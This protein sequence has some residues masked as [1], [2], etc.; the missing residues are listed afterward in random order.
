MDADQFLDTVRQSSIY[1]DQLVHVRKLA[2]RPARYSD[3]RH[4]PSGLLG[5]TIRS[6]GIDRLYTHQAEA[7]DAVAAGRH[8]VLV[9]STASGKTLSY[10]LPVL[11]SLFADR[12]ARAIYLFP[13]KALAQDQRGKLDAFGLMPAIR[14]ATYDGDTP[15]SERPPIRRSA[16]IILT[17][18]DML[19]VGILPN[20]EQWAHFF[21]GLKFV[22]IDEIH[23]YRGV[24]G[25]H[26][27]NIMRRLRRIAAY[28]GA[29]PQ[30]ICC[31]AT[32]HNPKELAETLTGLPFAQI[33]NDG[34][35][36]G[37]RTVALWNPPETADG[38][39]RP[40]NTEAT[41][42]FLALVAS[43]IRSI[44][45]ARARVTVELMLQYARKTLNVLDD[46]SVPLVEAYRGGYTPEERRDIEKRL[47]NGSL[48]GVATTNALEL[49]VD[50]GGLDAA[51][52][53]GYPGSI[54]SFWQQIGRVGRACEPS[55]SV[56]IA[57]ND[58]LEQY[59]VRRPG[60]LLDTPVE[61]VRTDP[62][63]PYVLATHLK[64]ATFE[65]PLSPSELPMFGANAIGI[66]ETM[67][68]D[69]ELLYRQ[70]RWFLPTPH[71]PASTVSIRSASGEIYTIL[72]ADTGRLMGTA[73]ADRAFEALH[74]GAVYLHRGETHIVRSLNLVA[75][76]ALVAPATL[77]YYTDAISE[78]AVEVNHEM[79]SKPLGSGAVGFGAVTITRHTMGFTRRCFGSG[80][81]LGYEELGLPTRSFDTTAVWLRLPASE[82]D[83][84][85][86]EE[87]SPDEGL[88][89]AQGAHAIEHVAS[90]LVPALV[91]CDRG[92]IGSAWYSM[93][94][95]TQCMT[96]FV[97]DMAP[98]GVGLA[99]EAYRQ[100]EQWIQAVRDLIAECPCLSGCP[101]CVLSPRCPQRNATIDKVHA[102][103]LLD[104]MVAQ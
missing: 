15:K 29:N 10:N 56:L 16:S 36:K 74:E 96:V 5:E 1:A 72:D 28:Y 41:T 18:P 60:M 39:R 45:F 21:N 70:G 98:G 89:E 87:G 23:I 2:A 57:H 79:E 97:F 93:H 82:L 49:G 99:E 55:L 34:S 11:E 6:M 37:Q 61:N 13:T 85:V 52:L 62:G 30:F 100:A 44:A 42:L 103:T 102:L 17:N 64:C 69:G 12:S 90:A 71:S 26:V 43:G 94:P 101:G 8:I 4:P 54:A 3:P 53:N 38:G 77:D 73:D 59:L 78:T 83:D 31:S 76:H 51:L 25:A 40:P 95:A 84:L 14:C 50:I 66:A 92:D 65:Q 27:G 19:H 67:E 86:W 58:P 46:E 20:H 47:F 35:P 68:A 88:L 7:L 24:F 75:K 63:N 91:S 22:V 32:I 104:R 48:L 33:D 9:T 80:A 81:I